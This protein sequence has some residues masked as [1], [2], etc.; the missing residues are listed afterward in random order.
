[1]NANVPTFRIRRPTGPACVAAVLA[2]VIGP[3]NALAHE[4]TLLVVNR[5]A[6]ASSDS[7]DPLADDP[8]LRC[9]PPGMPGMMDNSYPGEEIKPFE[10]ATPESSGQDPAP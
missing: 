8:A 3:A 7:Y 4:G 5:H 9:V 1:M 2:I 10:C 6:D